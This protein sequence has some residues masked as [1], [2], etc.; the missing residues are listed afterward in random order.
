MLASDYAVDGTSVSSLTKGS[1]KKVELVCD[2]C[3]KQSTTNWN[4]YVQGQR[5]RG[6]T[7]ETYCQP[8]VARKIGKAAKGKKN[9]AV[10]QANRER[11]GERHPSW[12]GGRY[13]DHHGYVMVSVRSGRAESGSGW[14]NYRKEHVL[15][16]EEDLK[17]PLKKG[18][19]VHHIDGDK[20]NNLLKNLWLTNQSGHRTAHISLQGIGF[21][22]VRAGLI[23]FN[24]DTGTYV[25]DRKLRELLEHPES[26]SDHNVAGNGERDG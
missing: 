5:K 17:R 24:A 6:W 1:T 18:E 10:S 25:A 4:N 12:K 20:L 13:V 11:S 15:V 23:H 8:C 9:P 7:G 3:G 2:G 16:M 14:N 19:V 22:L 26:P 21:L